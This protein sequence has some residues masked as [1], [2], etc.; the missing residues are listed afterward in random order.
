MIDA[1]DRP[2]RWL[3]KWAMLMAC[4][5]LYLALEDQ[6]FMHLFVEAFQ[7]HITT[8]DFFL[9][10]ADLVSVYTFGRELLDTSGESTGLSTAPRAINLKEYLK[11]RQ[12]G[13]MVLTFIGIIIA[14]NILRS[15]FPV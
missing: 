2:P 10:L 15:F 14:Y 3:A 4:T 6:G 8:R 9:L 13:S 1:R 5:H 7:R 11:S 12:F